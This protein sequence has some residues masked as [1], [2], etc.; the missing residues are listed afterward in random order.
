MIKT[1]DQIRKITNE[2][3]LVMENGAIA[4]D[5]SD[6]YSIFLNDLEV[7]IIIKLLESGQID[8]V[9][10]FKKFLTA[11][12]FSKLDEVLV[13]RRILNF[14]KI[15]LNKFE[16]ILAV[17]ITE[18]DLLF[19]NI[20]FLWAML[21]EN[22]LI[23]ELF[24][25]VLYKSINLPKNFIDFVI[26]QNKQQSVVEREK[27]IIFLRNL[28]IIQDIEIANIMKILNKLKEYF[29]I[30]NFWNYSFRYLLDLYKIVDM[31][32]NGKIPQNLKFGIRWLSSYDTNGS[33][34][35]F[36]DDLF[37]KDLNSELSKNGFHLV[38]IEAE[39]SKMLAERLRFLKNKLGK[40]YFIILDYHGSENTF[41]F[42]KEK[43]F[44][45]NYFK[46]QVRKILRFANLILLDG[47]QIVLNGCRQGVE[48]G[49]GESLAS[50][51]YKIF[52]S[53]ENVNLTK[54]D[55]DE[56]GI[57]QVGHLKQEN[58]IKIA[59]FKIM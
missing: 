32:E 51:R 12:Q 17:N 39:N 33:W 36:Q 24:F 9:V 11:S 50:G 18:K 44:S 42:S 47:G 16:N 37:S 14:M 29:G 56:H 25:S 46:S 59:P 58:I 43:I 40:A 8:P 3:S 23:K 22:P 49:F 34:Q 10:T 31:Y 13:Y 52:A 7:E 54:I 6:F 53:P 45:L 15:L 41:A 27:Q 21:S 57:V 55:M 1:A 48:G 19:S 5:F 20:Y 30:K 35:I 28:S 4:A 38:S 2:E 26:L